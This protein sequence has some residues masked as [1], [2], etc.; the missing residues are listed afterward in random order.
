MTQSKKLGKGPKLL[1]RHSDGRHAHEKKL[2]NI[3][4][5][6]NAS[7]NHN[8]LSPHPCEN[9]FYQRLQTTNV[10]ENV[11]KKEHSFTGGG[12]VD[13]SSLY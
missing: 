4:Y 7:G 8:E 6:R 1:Q 3:T 5:K 2:L 10:G 13:G 9:G 12:N 11:E